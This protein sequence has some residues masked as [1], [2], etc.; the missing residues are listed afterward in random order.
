MPNVAVNLNEVSKC[1]ILKGRPCVFNKILPEAKC[2]WLLEPI[3]EIAHT[4]KKQSVID[5]TQ[6][7]CRTQTRIICG[8]VSN[9]FELDNLAD[10]VIEQDH[11]TDYREE[12]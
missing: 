1:K 10:L 11:V 7:G 4:E 2:V 8:L 3:Y 12:K 9:Y 5:E 6:S